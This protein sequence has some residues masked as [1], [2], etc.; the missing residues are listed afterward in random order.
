LKLQ[1]DGQLSNIAFSFDLR[2]YTKVFAAVLRYIYTG[3]AAASAE[4]EEELTVG[5]GGLHYRM[6]CHVITLITNPRVL[7]YTICL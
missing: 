6:A 7:S 4:E 1:Y 2:R 3:S 5:P